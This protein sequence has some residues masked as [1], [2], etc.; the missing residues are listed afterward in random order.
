[1]Q[2][3]SPSGRTPAPTNYTHNFYPHKPCS[4]CFNLYHHVSDCLASR[5]FSNSSWEQMNTNFSSP[6]FKSNSNF[7]NSDWSNHSNFSWQTQATRNYAPPHN[8]LHYPK[9]LQFENQVLNPSSYDPLPQ[10]SSLEDAL[11]EFMERTGKSTIQVPQP[12][13]SLEDTVKA[14]IQASSQ[15]IQE[16]KSVT[17]SN[18]QIIQEL[19]NVTMSNDQIMQE[20]NQTIQELKTATLRDG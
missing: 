9:Y 17:T 8:E 19:K 6:R 16:L 18:N 14:F 15:N 1:M 2:H 3:V 20:L 4:Y 10:R 7:Y 13:L 12:E 5:Q 11:K